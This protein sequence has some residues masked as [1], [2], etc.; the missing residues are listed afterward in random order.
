MK[1]LR[2]QKISVD[3]IKRTFNEELPLEVTQSDTGNDI[4]ISIMANDKKYILDDLTVAVAIQLPNNDKII[5]HIP[6]LYYIGNIVQWKP[7]K[8]VFEHPGI[9]RCTVR[10]YDEIGGRVTTEFF[11]INVLPQ[12]QVLDDMDFEDSIL[13]KVDAIDRKVEEHKANTYTKV[14]ADE[15]VVSTL[16][17]NGVDVSGEAVTIKKD[18]VFEGSIIQE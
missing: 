3:L 15:A 12:I 16:S 13:D 2:T 4:F 9:V 1:N 7:R 14:E 5:D 17:V 18:A 6:P 10:I 11:N 8:T